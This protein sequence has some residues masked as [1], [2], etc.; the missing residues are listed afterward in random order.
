M[1]DDTKDP[2]NKDPDSVTE[3]EDNE[4]IQPEGEKGGLEDKPEPTR[5]G[6]WEIDGRVTDF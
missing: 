2:K 5:Y 3:K 4:N 1:T 6:D